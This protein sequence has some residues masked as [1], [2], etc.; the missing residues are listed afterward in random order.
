MKLEG[1]EQHVKAE[2]SSKKVKVEESFQNYKIHETFEERGTSLGIQLFKENYNNHLL[3]CKEV[4]FEL[5]YSLKIIL[6]S[7]H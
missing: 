7:G 2:P 4:Y 5:G 1:G 3:N 6:L